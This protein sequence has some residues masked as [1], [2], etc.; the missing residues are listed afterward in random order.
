MSDIADEI[1]VGIYGKSGRANAPENQNAQF[2]HGFKVG[3]ALENRE[4][5]AAIHDEW[6]VRTRLGGGTEDFHEWK[7]GLW[8]AVLQKVVGQALSRLP[9][10]RRFSQPTNP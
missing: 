3:A 2:Q 7:R 5:F 10:G 1:A 8:A 9:A 6:R 4:A